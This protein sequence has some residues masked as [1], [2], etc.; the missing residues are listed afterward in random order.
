MNFCKKCG[1][2]LTEDTKLCTGCGSPVVQDATMVSQSAQPETANPKSVASK[3]KPIDI[4]KIG[5]AGLICIF[6]YLYIQRPYVIF[7]GY[8]EAHIN[9]L[10]MM[11]CTIG[12]LLLGTKNSFSQLESAA[13]YKPKNNVLPI[14]LIIGFVHIVLLLDFAIFNI[15]DDSET[16]LQLGYLVYISFLF[17]V[18]VLCLVSAILSKKIKQR[19][20]PL[21]V[22]NPLRYTHK[23]KIR[24]FLLCLFL[25]MFG[26]HRFYTGKIVSG[27]ILFSLTVIGYMNYWGVVN[28]LTAPLY[29]IDSNFLGDLANAIPSYLSLLGLIGTIWVYVD[30]VMI[31]IGRFTDKKG[32]Q[33]GRMDCLT[34]HR[35]GERLNPDTCSGVQA[36]FDMAAMGLS[37]EIQTLIEFA[38][39]GGGLG[40]K[41]IAF[42]RRKAEEA[43]ENPDLAEMAAKAQLT[44]EQKP[45]TVTVTVKPRKT[46]LASFIHAIDDSFVFTGRASRSDFWQFVLVAQFL[47]FAIFT[48]LDYAWI[49]KLES[50]WHIIAATRD[51][52]WIIVLGSLLP[53]V[54]LWIR[55]IHDTG[56]SGWFLLVPVYNIFLLFKPGTVGQNKFGDDPIKP[57]TKEVLASNKEANA[58]FEKVTSMMEK[59]QIVGGTMFGIGGIGTQLYANDF[60]RV[61]TINTTTKLVWIFGLGLLALSRSIVI[62]QKRTE[63]T[64]G[65]KKNER[66]WI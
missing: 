2:K 48:A 56:K 63:N 32:F 41:E 58:T 11:V 35:T 7:I 54:S 24:V 21:L 14:A 8:N 43:G 12:V 55:R 16:Y 17:A 29:K 45:K 5:L 38:V 42:I 19:E 23:K 40:A 33:L 52:V 36:T 37:Q 44:K 20:N 59:L 9:T 1:T 18:I 6:G 34:K 57:V 30:I 3:T 66:I 65:G 26:A 28:T 61:E 50:I 10:I 46:P 62:L 64:S 27:I 47:A 4:I 49:E 22:E 25:G 13:K 53:M 51:F 39:A 60:L 15:I 31:A